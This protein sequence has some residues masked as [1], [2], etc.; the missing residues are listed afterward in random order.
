MHFQTRQDFIQWAT[1]Q[2]LCAQDFKTDTNAK[3]NALRLAQEVADLFF[4][5]EAAVHRAGGGKDVYNDPPEVKA[6]PQVRNVQPP[7]PG[8][9]GPNS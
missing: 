6:P 8:H 1:V 3:D 9:S 4:D 5:K 7:T 2:I